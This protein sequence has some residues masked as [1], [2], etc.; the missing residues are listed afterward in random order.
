M[1]RNATRKFALTVALL[2]LIASAGRV[3]AQS[4]TTTP[5]PADPSVITGT[6]PEPQDD[7]IAAI[8]SIFFLA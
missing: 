5:P 3:L 2:V 8:L 7:I 4:S 6:N 1:I